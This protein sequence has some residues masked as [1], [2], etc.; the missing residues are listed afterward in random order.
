MKWLIH[1]ASCN[2]NWRSVGLHHV[3]TASNM[4]EINNVH[5]IFRARN[6]IKK[7]DI[8]KASN[9]T[10]TSYRRHVTITTK[11]THNLRLRLAVPICV[12]AS[13]LSLLSPNVKCSL[14]GMLV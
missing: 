12:S 5:E 6:L 1:F 2:D 3:H 14:R 9:Y 11:V 7:T 4:P 10:D 8:E 13:I